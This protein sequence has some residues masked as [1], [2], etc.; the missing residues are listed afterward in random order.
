MDAALDKLISSCESE[1]GF[2]KVSL[3]EAGFTGTNWI[4]DKCISE[5]IKVLC[6]SDPIVAAIFAGLAIGSTICNLFFATDDINEQLYVMKKLKILRGLARNV[7]KRLQTRFL[8]TENTSL[9]KLFNK[10]VELYFNIIGDVD[11]ECMEKFLTTLY[12]GGV[13]SGLV[14]T[15]YGK[16]SD[17]VESLAVLNEL[18]TTRRENYQYMIRFCKAILKLES[19]ESFLYWFPPEEQEVVDDEVKITGLEVSVYNTELNMGSFDVIKTTYIPSNTTQTGVTYSSSDPGILDTDSGILCPKKTGTVT[20]TVT[21]IYDK[22]IQASV[23]IT[24]TDKGGDSDE[25]EITS[26]DDFSYEIIEN[27][28]TITGVNKAASKIFISSTI[29]GYT[30]TAIGTAAFFDNKK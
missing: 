2:A 1:N 29:K 21:S 14:V 10:S 17:Y 3:L 19:E 18:R 30:V 7:T 12:T 9:G 24:V 13:L 26:E 27:N 23:T 28:I 8:A 22:N 20:I 5:G 25:K 6:M 11:C 16:E 4:V 15:V